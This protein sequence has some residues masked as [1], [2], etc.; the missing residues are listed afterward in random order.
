MKRGDVWRVAFEPALG[1][2][3]RARVARPH[4]PDD[5]I[6]VAGV[7]RI[8]PLNFQQRLR[9]QFARHTSSSPTLAGNGNPEGN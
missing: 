9:R 4:V 3:L 6:V 2:A 5:T 7:D 1:G 8:A